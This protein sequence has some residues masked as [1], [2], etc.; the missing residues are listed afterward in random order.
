M[1]LA[2]ILLSVQHIV[3]FTVIFFLQAYAILVHQFVL[4]I[5]TVTCLL[6]I[7]AAVAKRENVVFTTDLVFNFLSVVAKFCNGVCWICGMSAR[8]VW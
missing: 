8:L 1:V 6:Q 2:L 5:L 4:M 3:A 7:A